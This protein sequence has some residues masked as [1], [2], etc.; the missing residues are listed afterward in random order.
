MPE[1]A[2]APVPGLTSIL[3]SSVTAGSCRDA[4]GAAV[5]AACACNAGAAASVAKAVAKARAGTAI[6]VR[7]MR[8]E[9]SGAVGNDTDVQAVGCGPVGRHA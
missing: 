6:L 5:G 8:G 7:Y 4:G 2:S 9:V 1:T 3:E